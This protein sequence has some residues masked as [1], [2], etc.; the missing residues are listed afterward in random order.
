MLESWSREHR[1][2]GVCISFHDDGKK[3]V[4][5]DVEGVC[6]AIAETQELQPHHSALLNGVRSIG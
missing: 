6:P 4:Y 5:I 2:A 1:E 3:G